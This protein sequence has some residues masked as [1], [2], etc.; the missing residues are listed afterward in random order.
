MYFRLTFE[1]SDLQATTKHQEEEIRGFHTNHKQSIQ[2]LTMRLNNGKEEKSK[3]LKEI[4]RLNLEIFD[5]QATNKH[6]EEEIEECHTN[7]NKSF[8]TLTQHLENRNEKI[9]KLRKEIARLEH[10]YSELQATTN[11]QAEESRKCQKNHNKLIQELKM[12]LENGKQEKSKL[13]KEIDRLEEEYSELQ[14][15]TNCQAEE[16]RKCQKNQA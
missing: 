12:R 14:A 11:C 6:Q 16:S 5:L 7:H 13:L 4:N 2:A 3:L 9:I 8:Q 1:V 15:T 10:E